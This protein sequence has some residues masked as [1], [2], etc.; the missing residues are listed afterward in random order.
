MTAVTRLLLIRAVLSFCIPT[1]TAA[2][3]SE[4]ISCAFF[5]SSWSSD[6]ALQ[7]TC[8]VRRH[9][10]RKFIL[11]GCCHLFLPHSRVC[12]SFPATTPFSGIH[13]VW[14]KPCPL[15]VVIAVEAQPEC[16]ASEGMVKGP[17]DAVE[18]GGQ[19]S[20]SRQTTTD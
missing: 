17:D 3:F 18:T 10:L 12:F 5:P 9:M 19:S 6:T 1:K 2:S 4:V 8:I 14:P 11:F 13:R 20:C 15:S 16:P 7:V